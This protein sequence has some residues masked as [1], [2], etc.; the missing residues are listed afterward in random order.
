MTYNIRNADKIIFFENRSNAHNARH[1][2]SG[3]CCKGSPLDSQSREAEVTVNQQIIQNDVDD[4]GG[5]VGTHGNSGISRTSLCRINSHLNAVKNHAAHDDAEVGNRPV[6]GIGGRS[7]EV[8]NRTGKGNEADAQNDS[9]YDNKQ[10][11]RVEDFIGR[12]LTLLP[13][14]SGNQC[15]NCHIQRKE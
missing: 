6:M 3:N 5:Y 8:H 4:I 12:V 9:S 11:R 7:A 10:D 1:H 2:R 14:S 15:G 13:A